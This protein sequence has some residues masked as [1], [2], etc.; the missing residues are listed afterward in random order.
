MTTSQEVCLAE[1]AMES[2]QAQNDKAA[3]HLMCNIAIADITKINVDDF[4]K[5]IT[6]IDMSYF[7][8]IK[9]SEFLSL[10]WNGRDKKIYAPN[11]VESTKWFNQINFWVQKEILKYS[12]VNKRTEMLSYFIKLAKRLVDVNNLYSAMSIIS[13]LQVECIYRL[14]LTWSGLGHRERASY[15]RLEELF[16][17]QEN[18]R[19]LREHTASM[20]LPGIPY[21][22]LY[23]SDLIY[24]NVAHPRINGQPT[25]VWVTKLNTI[26]DAIAHFQQSRFPYQTNES[27]RAYLLAQSY[28]EELQKFLEDAN[29]KVSLKLEPPIQIDTPLPPQTPQGSLPLFSN[30]SSSTST[31]RR[32]A[33]S[34]STKSGYTS[35]QDQATVAAT[36]P[37]KKSVIPISFKALSKAL[38]LEVDTTEEE[39]EGNFCGGKSGGKK[40]ALH[41]PNSVGPLE[42]IVA[43]FPKTAPLAGDL[44]ALKGSKQFSPHKLSKS[45]NSSENDSSECKSSLEVNA[46]DVSTHDQEVQVPFPLC[47][48]SSSST[49]TSPSMTCL[50][51]GRSPDNQSSP[52]KEKQSQTDLISDSTSSAN[53]FNN[54]VRTSTE[55]DP[56]TV[57]MPII[58]VSTS[59]SVPPKS[60]KI[61]FADQ[62]SDIY[63]AVVAVA[64]LAISQSSS[65]AVIETQSSS[66]SHTSF[67]YSSSSRSKEDISQWPPVS[68]PFITAMRPACV[69][70]EGPLF[71]KTVGRLIPPGMD[72]SGSGSGLMTTS[73][74]SED[75]QCVSPASNIAQP[76]QKHSRNASWKPF[77][78]AL[79]VMEGWSSAYMVYFDA[80]T[81]KPKRR[82][83]FSTSRCQIQPFQ[84]CAIEGGCID[85]LPSIGMARHRNGTVDETSFLLTHPGFHKTYRLRPLNAG[86]LKSRGSMVTGTPLTPTPPRRDSR[87]HFFT[88]SRKNSVGTTSSTPTHNSASTAFSS[89]RGRGASAPMLAAAAVTLLNL[90]D[91]RPTPAV[92]DWIHALQS[93]LDRLQPSF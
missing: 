80:I 7:A 6:L 56:L 9:R 47:S 22:G 20:R 78:S 49:L 2:R 21:L 48:D 26:V 35:D 10:K 60:P 82:E 50:L 77:W 66:D 59:N 4:V 12:A 8:A 52:K 43:A 90:T 40:M 15:R 55:I 45:R 91:A 11:I 62:S 33:S 17:Q 92:G 37:R 39:V 75:S 72:N 27:I 88:L 64:N 81:K 65:S 51:C 69:L 34:R 31:E 3:S 57:E 41:V 93:T 44:S 42:A 23:L 53:Q 32:S 71:R 76:Q 5:Q 24:T 13:A 85:C 87:R 63:S 68:F 14:R 79:V 16:G 73:T 58:P 1:T 18:C 86:E 74:F 89:L 84:K 25:T 54:S 28:I 36:V 19:L 67:S 83:D 70:C 30:G 38:T 61:P 29:Y 46:S